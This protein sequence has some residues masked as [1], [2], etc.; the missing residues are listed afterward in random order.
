MNDVFLITKPF[1]QS[2]ITDLYYK[3]NN[4]IFK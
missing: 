2:A 3:C 4:K 1:A